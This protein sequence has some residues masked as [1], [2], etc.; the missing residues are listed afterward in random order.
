MSAQDDFLKFSEIAE[1]L[2]LENEENENFIS[3][4]MKRRGHKPVLTWADAEGDGDGD[5]NSGDF[6]SAKRRTRDT[7]AKKDPRKTGWQYGA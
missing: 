6:F 4:A 2:G 5:G 7:S 3:S 1:L